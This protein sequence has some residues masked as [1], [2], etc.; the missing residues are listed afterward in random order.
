MLH[1]LELD[2]QQLVT[3]LPPCQTLLSSCLSC[4]LQVVVLVANTF[5]RFPKHPLVALHL[6]CNWASS[7]PHKMWSHT[8]LNLLLAPKLGSFYAMTLVLH[9]SLLPHNSSICV[10]EDIGASCMPKIH[11][12]SRRASLLEG[13]YP[14]LY[15]CSCCSEKK[16]LFFSMLICFAGNTRFF[17]LLEAFFV[18]LF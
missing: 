4:N 11:S 1:Y 5:F 13:S 18:S 14:Y 2:S 6:L 15:P 7:Y 17:Q 9:H 3:D 16:K 8:R 10:W 12:C